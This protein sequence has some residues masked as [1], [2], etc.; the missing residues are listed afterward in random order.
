MQSGAALRLNRLQRC[1]R[2]EPFRWA[3]HAGAVGDASEIAQ[4]HA[5][6]VIVGHGDAQPVVRRQAHRLADEIAVVDD[7]VV[8]ERRAFGAPVVPEVNWML[9]GSSNWS[10]APKAA[11]AL[12]SSFVAGLA[13]SSKLSM[14]GVFSAPSR[15][16]ISSFGSP[17]DV[18]LPGLAES[19]S[20][21]LERKEAK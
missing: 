15:M 19:I 12:R 16:T 17:A 14:P 1:E 10:V 2:I 3:H 7:V 20:G 11:S 4:H 18:S 5:E 6:A 13:T 9:I 8:G 21:A